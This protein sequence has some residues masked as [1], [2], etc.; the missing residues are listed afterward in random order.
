MSTMNR[1]KVC[2]IASACLG[3]VLPASAA[4]HSRSHGKT[5]ASAAAKRSVQYRGKTHH[6]DPISFT[7]SGSR[8]GKVKGY[9]PTLCL[10]TEGLPMSGTDAFD[11]PGTFALGH[12]GK[13]TAKRTNSI[14][15][16]SDVTKNFTL[17]TKR[18]RNGRITGSLHADFSFLMILYTYPISA[19]P[20]V[21][22]GDTTFQAQ[23]KR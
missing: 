9:A 12:T 20:Y 14:W 5:T 4:A 7:L 6:G 3:V 15:N 18:G 8:I 1:L 16:T 2:A 19:R 17:N 11:P 13:A 10:A 21:C 23:P 22:T